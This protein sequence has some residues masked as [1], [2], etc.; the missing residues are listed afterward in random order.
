VFEFLY[1]GNE[2]NN[3]GSAVSNEGSNTLLYMCTYL[4]CVGVT[5][6]NSIWPKRPI[7]S[8]G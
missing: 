6:S 5:K 8:L 7:M 3:C 1:Y 4:I 2:T